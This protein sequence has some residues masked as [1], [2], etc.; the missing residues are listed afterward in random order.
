M[1]LKSSV[2]VYTAQKYSLPG[3]LT[4]PTNQQV[5]NATFPMEHFKEWLK[6]KWIDFSNQH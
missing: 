5:V 2:S 6:V 1:V 4:V 3:K